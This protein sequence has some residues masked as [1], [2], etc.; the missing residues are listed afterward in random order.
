MRGFSRGVVVTLGL[1][2]CATAALS[3]ILDDDDAM[4]RA[5][6]Q[7]YAPL[8]DSVRYDDEDVV[9]SLGSQPIHFQGGRM[10]AAGQLDR[11]EVC[12]PI[13]YAYS[14]EPLT[15]PLP[16]P[17]GL[18][19][20]C[21]DVLE[22]LWGETESEIRT[23][24]QSAVFLEHRMF[25]NDLLIDPLD[26]VER[27]ILEAA[28]RDGSVAR[29]IA[30]LEIT[31]SFTYREIAGSSTRSYHAWGLAID[32]VPS[33]YEGLAVYWQWSRVFDREGWHQIP[34]ER[35]WSPPTTVIEIFERHGFV[36]GGKWTHFDAIHFEYRPDILLYNRLIAQ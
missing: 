8:I 30:E 1:G 2:V 25:V 21:T 26:A 24:G 35:R 28:S 19:A 3:S 32:L 16:A 27:D 11:Y 33:S 4:V 36:W 31:Y 7:A 18:P 5:F 14:L 9:F 20:Q 29:W 34:I 15:E 12:D 13:F 17:D 23:H 10:L 22:S 6:V